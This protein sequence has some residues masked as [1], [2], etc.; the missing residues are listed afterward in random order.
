MTEQLI[1]AI[2]T[3]LDSIPRVSVFVTPDENFL[4]NKARLPAIGIKDGTIQRSEGASMSQSSN[5]EV[6]LVAWV[7]L[8][9]PEASVLGD[10]STTQVGVIELA[11]AIHK[12][13]DDNL[14]GIAGITSAFSSTEAG[15][16]LMDGDRKLLVSKIITYNYDH[17]GDRPC[18][19]S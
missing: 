7:N 17:E 6:K 14:L 5:I 1:K 2:R 3:A 15:S 8:A 12:A 9:K 13:L 11:E 16:K 4:P 18:T 10:G 19:T